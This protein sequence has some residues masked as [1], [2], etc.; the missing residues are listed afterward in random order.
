MRDVELSCK[1]VNV[2]TAGKC[3][4]VTRRSTE[5]SPPILGKTGILSK[6]VEKQSADRMQKNTKNL[7]LTKHF[8]NFLYTWT[9]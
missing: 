3:H 5:Y 8:L 9:H 1:F 4:L 7:I 2:E 6:T